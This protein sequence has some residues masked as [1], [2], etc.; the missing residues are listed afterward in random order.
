MAGA[1]LSVF[2]PPMLSISPRRDQRPIDELDELAAAHKG[3]DAEER[4]DAERHHRAVDDDEA[5]QVGRPRRGE[6]QVLAEHAGDEVVEREAERR[7]GDDDL[8]L[9]QPIL[10]LVFSWFVLEVFCER[11]VVVSVFGSAVQN[12][13]VQNKTKQTPTTTT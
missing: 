6:H 3:D 4:G 13:A 9:E 1:P 8:Q 11:G 12:K 7:D 5:S 10:F 2:L